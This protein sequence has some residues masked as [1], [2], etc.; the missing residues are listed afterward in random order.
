MNNA[1]AFY[2]FFSSSLLLVIG[3]ENF[4]AWFFVEVGCA[5]IRGSYVSSFYLLFFDKYQ[6]VPV[7]ESCTTTSSHSILAFLSLSHP[8]LSLF[9]A[10]LPKTSFYQGI[11]IKDKCFFLNILY[12]LTM[13]N[14]V[15]FIKKNMLFSLYSSI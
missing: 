2:L 14:K 6:V 11:L 12:Y 10:F 3:G 1:L 9:L 13:K 5:I 8:L 15:K 4:K 7:W